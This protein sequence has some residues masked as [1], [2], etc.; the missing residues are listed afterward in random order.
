LSDVE[1]STPRI[2]EFLPQFLPFPQTERVEE[3]FEEEIDRD[4]EVIADVERAAEWLTRHGSQFVGMD[5][6]VFLQLMRSRMSVI[7]GIDA[8]AIEPYSKPSGEN[9]RFMFVFYIRPVDDRLPNIVLGMRTDK[10]GNARIWT[11]EMI[12]HLKKS[13]LESGFKVVAVSADGDPHYRKFVDPMQN[14]ASLPILN[15]VPFMDM[16]HNLPLDD[17]FLTDFLHMMKCLSHRLTTNLL[18]LCS[19]AAHDVTMLAQLK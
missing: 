9:K 16:V 4:E 12:L 10:G 19:Q 15:G 8:V 17:L 18:A 5:M 7:L 11:D 13:C 1:D 6:M 3:Y 2:D 14:Q